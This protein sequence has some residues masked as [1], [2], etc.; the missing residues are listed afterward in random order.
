MSITSG[1]LRTIAWEEL[2]H[3]RKP[4]EIRI[5]KSSFDK[6]KAEVESGCLVLEP[7]DE[8]PTFNGVRLEVI[9]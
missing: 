9:D 1:L 2:R 8:P 5:T 7:T 4:D 3:G 6:L